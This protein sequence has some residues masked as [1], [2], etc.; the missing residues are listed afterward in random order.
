[1]VAVNDSAS[2][3]LTW[4]KIKMIYYHIVMFVNI[5]VTVYYFI[6]RILNNHILYNLNMIMHLNVLK[7]EYCSY[8]TYVSSVSIQTAVVSSQLALS[9]I[10][11]NASL[12][13]LK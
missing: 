12:S 6:F 10:Q 8:F 2:V 13:I 9:Y 4:T 5:N 1:M 3:C 7:M 11:A